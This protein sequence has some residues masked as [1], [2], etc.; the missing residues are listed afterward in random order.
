MNSEM[1]DAQTAQASLSFFF[2]FFF[3]SPST[4]AG[5][6]SAS[7]FF[8]CTWRMGGPRG[9]QL[10]CLLQTQQEDN[11]CVAIQRL[12]HRSKTAGGCQK[13]SGNSMTEKTPQLVS[14]VLQPSH[15][16]VLLR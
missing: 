7:R 4:A 1:Q 16:H 8:F 13:R 15:P 14:F 6:S 10:S 5:S 2:F 3:F 12:V 9:R 11:P